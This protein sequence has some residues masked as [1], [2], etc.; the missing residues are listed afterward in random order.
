MR[1]GF[2]EE[3]A[4]ALIG[5]AIGLLISTVI[6]WTGG[7]DLKA[8][9]WADLAI[10][11]ILAIRYVIMGAGLGSSF[12]LRLAWYVLGAA[13]FGFCFFVNLLD[14]RENHDIKQII[15]CF[16]FALI[17]VRSIVNIVKKLR[18][19]FRVKAARRPQ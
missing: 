10:V 11:V 5:L 14:L 15:C 12:I 3:I 17:A 19:Y 7:F 4:P 13:V 8:M 2:K 9:L 18:Q 1:Q 6:F 16:V